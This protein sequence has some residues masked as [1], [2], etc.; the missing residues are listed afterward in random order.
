[1]TLNKKK[2]VLKFNF[3][4]RLMKIFLHYFLLVFFRMDE[5]EF[6]SEKWIE[7]EW[8]DKFDVKTLEAKV[9]KTLKKTLRILPPEGMLQSSRTPREY[10]NVLKTCEERLSVSSKFNDMNLMQMIIRKNF[11]PK[12]GSVIAMEFMRNFLFNIPSDYYREIHP[13]KLPE[14]TLLT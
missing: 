13:R 7:K 5:S 8:P 6:F 10:I 1:M 14:P 2:L 4:F 9:R 12:K 3:L 11:Y